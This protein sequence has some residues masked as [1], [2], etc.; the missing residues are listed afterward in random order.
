MKGFQ[1][2]SQSE[3]QSQIAHQSNKLYEL[4]HYIFTYSNEFAGKI[5]VEPEGENEKNMITIY[6]RTSSGQTISIKCDKKQ[7]AMSILEEV[8]IRSAIPRSMTFLVHHEKC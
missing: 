4:D 8:E 2:V 3:W 5:I 6:V 7:R 1:E